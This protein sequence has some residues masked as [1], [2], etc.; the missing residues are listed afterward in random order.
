MAI[1]V[2]FNGATIFKPGAYS[3][4]TIDLGGGF[5]IGPA[6]LIAVFGEADAGKPGAQEVDIKNNRF[7][8]DQLVSIRNKYRS[9]PIA[10]AAA[11]LFAPA[12]DAGIPSGAQTVWFYKTNNSTQATLSLATAYGTLTSQEWGV[13][14]NRL[15]A[16]ITLIG[17]TAPTTTGAAFDEGALAGGETFSFTPNGDVSLTNTFT[18]VAV[19]N[20]AAMVAAIANAGNWSLGAPSGF[21]AVVGGADAAT[22]LTIALD[23]DATA[24]QNGYGRDFEL[25]ASA[26]MG[27][28]A[29]LTVAAVEPSVT[30][31]LDQKRDDIQ[32][33]EAIGGSIVMSIGSDGTPGNT[34]ASITVDA[35]SII[36]LEDAVPT[37]TLIK[38]SFVTLK[39]IEDEINLKSGWTASISDTAFNQSSPDSLD[40]VAALGAFSAAGEQPARMKSDADAVAFFFENSS[41]VTIDSQSATGLPDSLTET[42]MTGGTKGATTPVDIINALDKFTKFHVNSLVP[43]FSRD[44]TDDI[45]DGLTEATSTY[46]IDGVH[47]AIKTHISLMKTTKKKSERQGY[48]ALKDDFITSKSKAGDLADARL[49]LAIQDVRQAD[50]QGNIRFFQPHMFSAILAGARGGAPIGEPMTFKFMNVSGARHTAQPLSTAEEDVNVDFDPD[51][52]SDEAIQAGITFMES[53]QT[54]GFR[55]VVDNT[56][57][58]VDDSFIYNR[59]NVLYAADIV[60][61]NFRNAMEAAFV[62]KKNTVTVNDVIGTAES[63]LTAFLGQGVTVSTGDAPSGFKNLT[64]RIEGNTIFVDVVVKI[65]EGIDFILSE[66]TIQR[67]SN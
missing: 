6:G 42:S 37:Y 61:F 1:N 12:A 52:Q 38:S 33:E 20:N 27:L 66:I 16:E 19:A 51:L 57:Y 43:L 29:A 64:A 13:G 24:N 31:K 17:E 53:P 15:T 28:S 46:T 44:A 9:G 39:Q 50:A 23:A 30:L 22:T 25:T 65:V 56:T 60:A 4:T 21:T 62:G 59:A 11:F 2:S 32:E 49:Q 54:G 63:V 3:K 40:E 10:D 7:T 34:A 5:A 18:A 67:A 47:Q 26:P 41:L 14:G 36:L 58:G 35:S 8:A 55:V 45:A 48:L